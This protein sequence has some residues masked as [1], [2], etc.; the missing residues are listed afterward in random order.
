MHAITHSP[1]GSTVLRILAAILL[2]FGVTT[3]AIAQ[4]PVF[5][6][7]AADTAVAYD[8]AT[9]SATVC[10]ELSIS[11]DEN[12]VDFPVAIQGFTFALAHDA[13][14]LTPVSATAIGA[15][16]DLNDGDG[17]EYLA[18]NTAPEGADGMVVAVVF[19]ILPPGEA[20][21]TFESVTP[22]ISA[23]YD[24][25]A[26]TLIDDTDG[27]ITEL[28]W[29]DNLGTSPPVSNIV[30]VDGFSEGVLSESGMITLIA[31]VD[32]FLRGD[33]DGSGN[34]FAIVDA[35]YLLEWQ[36]AGGP[37]PP[38]FR[39]ADIDDNGNVFAIVDALFLLSWQFSN[40]PEPPAPGPISCGTDPTAD[41]LDCLAP[42]LC[43]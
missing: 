19:D 32:A 22:A 16:A 29:T 7:H 30:T 28:T 10:V 43:P 9:G 37:V 27:A 21:L 3:S 23:C 1:A 42:P 5:T 36:F 24:T 6:F 35:L 26:A 34:V 13:D 18:V 8:P 38:C 41:G 25:V 14:L 4:D 40:G 33:A 2:A 31:G 17:P 39:A 20:E 11:E 12:D 15:V